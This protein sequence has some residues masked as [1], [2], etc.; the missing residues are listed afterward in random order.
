MQVWQLGGVLPNSHTR[1]FGRHA[2]PILLFAPTLSWPV[3]G[4]PARHSPL[5]EVR[6][7]EMGRAVASSSKARVLRRIL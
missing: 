4:H 5:R 2:P 6:R 1:V 7:A 3:I